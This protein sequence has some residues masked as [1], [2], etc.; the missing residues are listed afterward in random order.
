MGQ[1]TLNLLPM[2]TVS[3]PKNQGGLNLPC[4][5]SKCDAL[6][7][8]QVLRMLTGSGGAMRHLDFWLGRRLGLNIP[9]FGSDFRQRR[10][11]SVCK[12]ILELVTE[13]VE[14]ERVDVDNLKMATTKSIYK[15]Y[16]ETL[17]PAAVELKYEERDWSLI[18]LRVWSPVLTPGA[19]NVLFLLV[20]EKISTKVRGHR[21]M[22]GR[23][24]NNLFPRYWEF[25]DIQT[26]R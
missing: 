15:S 18:W 2:E 23:Y 9:G 19:N 10:T 12:K 4:L 20:H 16:T 21:L 5:T 7:L 1:Q 25:P 22:P 13:A 26:D 8:K 14:C 17:P 11:P 24:E 3:L 6:F